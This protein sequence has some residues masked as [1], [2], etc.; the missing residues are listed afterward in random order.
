M[1]ATLSLFLWLIGFYLVLKYRVHIHVNIDFGA[2]R[3]RSK[4]SSGSAGNSSGDRSRIL[5]DTRSKGIPV[6]IK[7]H[8]DA[9]RSDVVSAL[10]GLGCQKAKARKVAQSVCAQPGRS[11]DELLRKAI[12]KAQAA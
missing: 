10:I 6:P 2:Q 3:T 12:Q 7:T 4:D 1:I 9:V 11:F 8:Q 5:D